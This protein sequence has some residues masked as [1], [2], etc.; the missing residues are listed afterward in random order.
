MLIEERILNNVDD[1][2]I[3]C[4][5]YTPYGIL[6]L[7]KNRQIYTNIFVEQISQTV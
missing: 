1:E 6:F 4:A 7:L 3:I 5:F 2:E